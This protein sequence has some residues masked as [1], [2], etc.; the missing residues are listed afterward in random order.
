MFAFLGAGKLS[1]NI[2][3]GCRWPKLDPGS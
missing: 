2:I 3:R 1:E